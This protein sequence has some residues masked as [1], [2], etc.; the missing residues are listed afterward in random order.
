[1]NNPNEKPGRPQDQQEI[2]RQR[3]Q[4]QRQDRQKQ[5]QTEKRPGFDKDQPQGGQTDHG[6]RE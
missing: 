2:Q 1:M 3:E 5:D 4:Q 6:K